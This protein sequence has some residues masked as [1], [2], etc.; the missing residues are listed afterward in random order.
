MKR[1]N[2]IPLVGLL[3]A[4]CSS[5][6][7][8]AAVEWDK[9]TTAVNAAF[10]DWHE[11]NV[12]VPSRVISGQ[13]ARKLTDWQGDAQNYPADVWYAVAHSTRIVVVSPAAAEFFSA[14]DWLTRHGATGVI[15]WQQKLNCLTCTT[16]LYFSR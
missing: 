5:P 15:A 16:D 11:N 12:V 2:L 14:R 8:P 4:G 1:F 13:W 7:E 3:L 9:P 10:P 6:P